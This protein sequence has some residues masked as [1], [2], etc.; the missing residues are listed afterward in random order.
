[1]NFR[2]LRKLICKVDRIEGE[3]REGLLRKLIKEIPK[4]DPLERHSEF[5]VMAAKTL[6]RVKWFSYHKYS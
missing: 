5:A 6:A 1:M 2:E 4:L 3:E